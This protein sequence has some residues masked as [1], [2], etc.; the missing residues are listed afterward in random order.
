MALEIVKTIIDAESEADTIV[1]NA[2]KQAEEIRQNTQRECNSLVAEFKKKCT[3]DK[4]DKIKAAV[5]KSIPEVEKII[6]ESEK[7]ALLI[8]ERAAQKA[9]KAVLAVIG[10]VVG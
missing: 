8:K 4:D 7:E 6:S 9:D 1:E 3:K 5:E 10:K 2:K